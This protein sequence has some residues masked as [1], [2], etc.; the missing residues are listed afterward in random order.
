MQSGG[1]AFQEI[2][3]LDEEDFGFNFEI[4]NDQFPRIIG[5]REIAANDARSSF[6]AATPL[7]QAALL[8]WVTPGAVRSIASGVGTVTFHSKADARL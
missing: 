8:G 1:E 3:M 2:Q 7:N 5:H 4:E 6:R